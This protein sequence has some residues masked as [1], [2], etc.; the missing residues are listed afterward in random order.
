MSSYKTYRGT[1]YEYLLGAALA[2]K[3]SLSEPMPGYSSPAVP[4]S[5]FVGVG[6][7]STDTTDLTGKTR[8]VIDESISSKGEDLLLEKGETTVVVRCR[9]GLREVYSRAASPP[10]VLE[11][12]EDPPSR[13]VGF[14][15]GG[16]VE[17]GSTSDELCACISG[18]GLLCSI[19]ESRFSFWAQEHSIVLRPS[20]ELH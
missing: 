10:N 8:S 6:L 15:G 18:A 7:G 13:G 2:F 17:G 9:G 11:D 5:R 4:S 12:A 19:L 20:V 16:E 14:W 1:K 3:P